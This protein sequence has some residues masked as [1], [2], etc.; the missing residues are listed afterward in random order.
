MTVQHKGNQDYTGL[1]TDTKP[2]A[3]AGSEFTETDTRKT[4]VNNGTEWILQE[5]NKI[6][7]YNVTNVGSTYYIMDQN[8]KV[9]GSGTD[10]QVVIQAI[11]DAVPTS[12]STIFN[13]DAG[14]FVLN[15]PI[16]IPS[17]T[18]TAAKRVF[19]YGVFQEAR[20]PSGTT[21]TMNTV[22]RTSTSFPTNRYVIECNNAAGSLTGSFLT[23]DGFYMT[24][25]DNVGVKDVG[26]L[27]LQSDQNYDRE[28]DIRN[29]SS[30]YAWRTLH[31]MGGVWWSRFVNINSTDANSAFIGDCDYT[32]ERGGATGS[33]NPTPK[34][35]Y[36]EN[37]R[38]I[39]QGQMSYFV[40]ILSGSYNNFNFSTF[41]AAKCAVA[42]VNLE[43]NT[44]STDAVDNNV[45]FNTHVLD[46]AAVPAPDTR[47]AGIYING[48]YVKNNWF[49][50]AFVNKI[51]NH[52]KIANNANRNYIL[53]TGH[54]GSAILAD[55]TTA[56]VGNTLEIAAGST[57]TDSAATDTGGNLR[58]IDK[59]RGGEKGGIATARTDGST[60]AH[61]LFTTPA[62]YFVTGTVAGQIVTATAD[63]TNLTLGIKTGAG[64]AG[65]SQSVAWRAGVY[66]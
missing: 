27:K 57:T 64:A 13:F 60:I 37:T 59:R 16:I 46:V 12:T 29:I 7:R 4:Y 62:W 20:Q 51:I 50:L 32:L 43:Q 18:N 21:A 1:S 49:F 38:S 23:M 44:T 34:Y 24:N 52:Y 47:Q 8:G 15:N 19:M 33:G 58:I 42:G 54:W 9:E 39:H 11:L 31:L 22:L 45:F 5:L 25:V 30:Q 14:N 36:F 3:S 61:G 63:A 40:R 35:N 26:F 48:Q 17:A 66:A 55:S 65:T 28:F 56:G 10:F 2:T 6:K 53:S 41:D